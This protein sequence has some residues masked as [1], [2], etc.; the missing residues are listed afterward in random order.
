MY[1]CYN[2][3]LFRIMKD[4]SKVLDADSTLQRLREETLLIIESLMLGKCSEIEN[5]S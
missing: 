5:I 2:L 3:I 4:C 1:N